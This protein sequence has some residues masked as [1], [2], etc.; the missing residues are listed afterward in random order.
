MSAVTDQA[1]VAVADGVLHGPAVR[2]MLEVPRLNSS[3]KSWLC[4][5]P[6]LPP[7]PYTWLMTTS[8]ITGGGASSLTM[9]PVPSASP[10]RGAGDV[11]EEHGELLDPLRMPGRR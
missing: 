2:L 9:V 10:T 6:E 3:M 7:P 4:V 1:P 8:D 11:G 5:A